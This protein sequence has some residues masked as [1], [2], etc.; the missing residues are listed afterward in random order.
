M[1]T[2]VEQASNH[3]QTTITV[4]PSTAAT[5]TG[6]KISMFAKKSGFVIPKNKLSGSLVPILR[7]KKG[8]SKTAS[9]ES[10]KQV[11]RK[12]KWGPDLSQDTAVRKGRALAYK[13]RVDQITKQLGLQSSETGGN[14]ESAS[15]G[16]QNPEVSSDYQ[17]ESE[18]LKSL[19][20]EKREAI[21]EILKLNPSYKCP[22]DYEPILKE[23]KVAIPIKAYPRHNIISLIFGPANDTQ[24]RLEKETGAKIRV[25]GTKVDTQEK[26]EVTSDG[27]EAHVAYEELHVHVS[28]DTYEK[29]DAAVALVELLVTPVSGNAASAS[30]TPTVVSGDNV[31]VVALSQDTSAASIS[32]GVLPPITVSTQVSQPSNFQQYAGPWFPTGAAQTPVFPS[33]DLSGPSNPSAAPISN[34]IHLSS[35]A[36]NPSNM[37]SLFGPRPIGIPGAGLVPQNPLLVP[38]GPQQQPLAHTYMPQAPPGNPFVPVS[39]PTPSHPNFPTMPQLSSNQPMLTV[40]PQIVG[41]GMS[42]LP[43]S[44][45]A[46]TFPNQ[47]MTSAG[48]SQPLISTPS[49]PG[50]MM[51]LVQ[52][53]QPLAGS[54]T[55]P[56]NLSPLPPQSGPR[57]AGSSVNHPM[58]APPFVASSHTQSGHPSSLLPSL[59]SAHTPSII[60]S[61]TITPMRPGIQQVSMPASAPNL[62]PGSNP[63]VSPVALNSRP[64]PPMSGFP[65]SGGGMPMKPSF[66]VPLQQAGSSDFTFQPRYSAS[67]IPRRP[68]IL[69]AQVQSNQSVQPHQGS[70]ASPFRP[71]MHTNP[72][73][74]MQG[75]SG[76]QVGNLMNRPRAQT[77][78]NLASPT[79]HPGSLRHGIFPNSPAGSG[80]Q[81]RNFA[82]APPHIAS[83]GLNPRGGVPTQIQQNYPPPA[84]R[85]QGFVAPS[86]HQFNSNISFRPAGRPASG[87]S[88]AQVYDPFSPTSASLNPQLNSSRV[89][90]EKQE[91]DPEYEDLMASVGVK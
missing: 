74:I 3:T 14:Q 49:G 4:S 90:M 27:P 2:K 71:I 79:A 86:N 9:E 44:T 68:N 25:Y 59:G 51:P 28:A 67:Q 64:Q 12:T 76:P 41:P 91:N 30:T 65:G 81:T 40:P 47:S 73:A 78:I 18:E 60:Q 54:G 89:N 1:S 16:L 35:S 50:N 70:Q 5:A 26:V 13:T 69:P 39:Q 11:Q 77:P 15:T 42:S 24:K 52:G 37:P 75:F 22:A 57:F 6:P 23:A 31:N 80:T 34:P 61:S 29:V 43:L 84:G 20:L 53:H 45:S 10:T 56:Q 38:S 87:S 17:L 7:G 62:V 83:A 33:Q 8:S 55:H 19:E 63:V 46:A 58:N 82:S 32:Q 36:L 85:P 48:W 21:G 72:S 88:G 66:S